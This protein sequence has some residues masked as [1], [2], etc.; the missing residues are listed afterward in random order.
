METR[1]LEYL[2][3]IES[4]EYEPAV[5]IC[6]LYPDETVQSSFTE[7]MYDISGTINVT[8]QSG[9]RRSCSL[10]INNNKGQF[11]IDYNNIWIGQKFQVWAG[12]YLNDGTPYYISQGIFYVSNPTESYNPSTK[13]ITIQGVDKW[14]FLN[15]SL[16]GYLTG[17]YKQSFGTD[18]KLSSISLLKSSKFSNYLE[19]AKRES[20]QIDPKPILFSP[21]F[22]TQ[23]R[24]KQQYFGKNADPIFQ[25]S[26]GKLYILR[27]KQGKNAINEYSYIEIEEDEDGGYKELGESESLVYSDDDKLYAKEE[28]VLFSPYTITLEAGKSLGDYFQEVATILGAN[29]YYNNF[30]YLYYEPLDNTVE[31]ISNSNKIIAWNYNENQKT[32]LGLSIDNDFTSFYNDIIVLGKVVN[33]HQAKARIQNQDDKSDLNI[34]RIGI[35][36][37][38]PYKDEK[39][40]TDSLCLDLAK[41]YARTEMVQNKKVTIQSLPLYHLDVNQLVTLTIK[42]K[43]IIEEKFLVNSFSLSLKGGTM[44]ISCNNIKNF[45]EWTEVP[46]YDR[47][48]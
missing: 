37:K 28:N 40:Y 8:Y 47:T 41:N 26:E 4:G 21:Y 2:D 29:V 27:S 5:K 42:E 39:Y 23:K 32:F 33:G 14:N 31:D 22:N 43:N 34:Y 17:V 45:A 25:N 11:P 7:A 9:A 3:K 12:V 1:F 44:S 16:F 19:M 38:P 6:W 30:G 13:T 20:D 36:S 35:K 24:L 10:V 46:I 18:L 15:G 48:I